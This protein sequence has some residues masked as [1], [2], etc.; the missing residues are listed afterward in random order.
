MEDY[1]QQQKSRIVKGIRYL[2]TEMEWL[3]S[4]L[5]IMAEVKIQIFMCM[6]SHAKKVHKVVLCH[7][8]VSSCHS[9]QLDPKRIFLIFINRMSPQALLSLERFNLALCCHFIVP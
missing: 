1:K 5:L 3:N 2:P 9:M 6:A 8:W 4:N 7:S